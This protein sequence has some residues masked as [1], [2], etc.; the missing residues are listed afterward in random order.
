LVGALQVAVELKVVRRIRLEAEAAVPVRRIGQVLREDGALWPGARAAPTD[1][2]EERHR[3]VVV[4]GH[5]RAVVLLDAEHAWRRERIE[6]QRELGDAPVVLAW[7]AWPS[8][9]IGDAS[10]CLDHLEVGRFL[11]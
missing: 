5:P 4:H 11:A 10:R 6:R 8:R 3:V 1:I 9:T 7:W 2:H